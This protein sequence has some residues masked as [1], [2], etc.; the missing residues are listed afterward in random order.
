MFSRADE[1]WNARMGPTDGGGS[2]VIVTRRHLLSPCSNANAICQCP[3]RYA[4]AYIMTITEAVLTRRRRDTSD[5]ERTTRRDRRRRHPEKPNPKKKDRIV[6]FARARAP[7]SPITFIFETS[8]IGATISTR[9]SLD[10][11]PVTPAS[12]RY[13][14]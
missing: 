7:L 11:F 2:C 1:K 9:C 3:I 13:F 4:R 8:L 12:V 14:D 6:R 10:F 5:R